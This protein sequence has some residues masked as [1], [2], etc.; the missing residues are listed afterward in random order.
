MT[1]DRRH[2]LC[3]A[4]GAIYR[5]SDGLCVSGPCVGA[6]LLRIEATQPA[7]E[8]LALTLR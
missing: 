7:P 6:S 8:E 2:L 4:H 1:D 5:P 3:H